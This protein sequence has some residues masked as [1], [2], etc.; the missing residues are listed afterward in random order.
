MPNKKLSWVHDIV[1]TI[2]THTG[3][4]TKRQSMEVVVDYNQEEDNFDV[5]SVF[6]TQGCITLE[7]S[8]LLHKAEGNP[9]NA[10]VEAID[11]KQQFAD[12]FSKE[13]SIVPEPE[14]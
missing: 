7:I 2:S 11:W 5:L 6:V 12:R 1:D 8:K 4:Y 9:L 10:M 13:E 3:D 14:Y